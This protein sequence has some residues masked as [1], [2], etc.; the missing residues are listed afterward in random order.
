TVRIP[1]GISDGATLRIPGSGEVGGPGST[2]GDLYV[3]VHIRHHPNYE[4]NGDDLH[5]SRRI[6]ITDAALGMMMDVPTIDGARATIK[7]PPGTQD[8]TSFRIKEKGMPHLQSKGFGDLFV[9][10]KIEIPTHLTAH[11]RKLLED[12]AQTL[13]GENHGTPHGDTAQSREEGGIFKK[14]FG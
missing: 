1:A 13:N 3:V 11:Q 5:Y 12:Y 6:S 8:S 10:V 7:I 2:A 14:I 4:R 9:K